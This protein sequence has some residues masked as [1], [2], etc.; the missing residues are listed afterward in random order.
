MTMGP[1]ATAIAIPISHAL[2]VPIRDIP[3][4]CEKI[5]AIG[6]FDAAARCV[7]TAKAK[8]DATMRS[9]EP[10]RDRL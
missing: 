5:R 8:L 9:A 7:A 1:T 3:I 10:S 4:S 2:G 6:Q